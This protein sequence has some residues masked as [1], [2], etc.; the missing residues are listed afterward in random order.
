MNNTMTP[1]EKAEI[2]SVVG[3]YTDEIKYN[4]EII[5]SEDTT[6]LL[7]MPVFY[8]VLTS[9]DEQEEYYYKN[10]NTWNDWIEFRTDVDLLR[11]F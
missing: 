7:N 10:I 11:L 2:M 6:G 9:L 3:Q 4:M 1:Q 5:H 8:G